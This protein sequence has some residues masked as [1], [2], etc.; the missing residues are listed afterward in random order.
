[1]MSKAL[2]SVIS[3]R[4]WRALAAAFFLGAL[5]TLAF[6]PFSWFFMV[7][8]SIIGLLWLLNTSQLNSKK[9][10]FAIGWW[11]GFGHF[12]TGLYW[13]AFALGVNLEQFWWLIP[14]SVLG[15]PAILSLFIAPI[16]LLTRI[17]ALKGLGQAIIFSMLWAVFEWLR[18][19]LFTGLPWNLIAYTWIPYES[20]SQAFSIFGAYGF[21][22]ITVFSAAL[23]YCAFTSNTFK[24]GSVYALVALSFCLSLWGFGK[25]RLS[26]AENGMVPGIYLRLVQ[27]N[28]PQKIKWD[29]RQL[30]KSVEHILG[31]ASSSTE[32]EITHILLPESAL[33][34]L[35]EHDHKRREILA[36]IIPSKGALVTGGIHLKRHSSSHIQIWNSVFIITAEGKIREIYDKSHLVPFG[37]YI[38]MRSLFPNSFKK[39]TAG[40]VDFSFGP[41]IRTLK[42]E[43]LPPFSPLICYEGIFPGEVKAKEG[44]PPQW[45]YNGTNDAWYG[46]TSGPHQHLAINRARA[47]EE[48]LPCMRVANTGISAV[49]DTYGRVRASL[50]LNT[51]GVIDTQL[52]LPSPL[53]T[54]Y[55]LYG[56]AIFWV[57]L[58][59]FLGGLCCVFSKTRRKND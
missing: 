47:I 3:V 56:D 36:K 49:I 21:G 8:F 18:G 53:P 51:T 28:I 39:I 2:A 17:F 37:E 50:P 35:I 34:F 52:P 14:F 27:P 45:L 38:P 59:I 12:T 46:D 23:L 9:H 55:S 13:I 48:G 15:L 7:F 25:W 54:L 41:G 40:S 29:P 43:G 42:V 4:P 44:E 33:P 22:L 30:D 11:F 6:E 16:T 1:M 26:H 31:L 57:I 32:K 20:M 24:N 10:A 19:H 58:G 5:G